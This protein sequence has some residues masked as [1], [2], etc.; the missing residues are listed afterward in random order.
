MTLPIQ[1]YKNCNTNDI[2]YND[3]T[4]CLGSAQME[5]IIGRGSWVCSFQ[6]ED[7]EDV[8]EE[9]DE[10]AKEHDEDVDENVEDGDEGVEQGGLRTG[11]G[12]WFKNS[13]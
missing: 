9:H 6:G 2:S 3:I 8:D 13:C 4:R 11:K 10:D 7:S 12:D 1:Q 5:N